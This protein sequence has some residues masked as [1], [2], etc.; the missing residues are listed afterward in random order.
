MMVSRACLETTG[1]LDDAFFA[2]HEDVDLCLRARASGFRVVMSPLS[3][4]WH[5]GGGSMGG[6]VSLAHIY[7]DV[8]N[9]LRLVQKHKP[10]GNWAMNLFRTGCIVGAHTVQVALNR[11]SFTAIRTIVAA[12]RDYYRGVTR[13]RPSGCSTTR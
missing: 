4:V 7:Y 10:A 2:F 9:G 13:A 6:V 11:P 8:R 12:T 1:G 5:E 3:R